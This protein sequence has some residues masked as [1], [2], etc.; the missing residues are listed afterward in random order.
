MSVQVP[1]APRAEDAP[2]ATARMR[3]LK[4]ST[5]SQGRSVHGRGSVTFGPAICVFAGT[6]LLLLVV[7]LVVEVLPQS[8][9]AQLVVA[10][11]AGLPFG[12]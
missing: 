12:G 5:R 10:L 2:E 3:A 11:C 4:A 8:P 7:A 1:R 9:F 6:G